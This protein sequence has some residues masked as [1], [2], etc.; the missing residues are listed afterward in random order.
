MTRKPEFCLNVNGQC[1]AKSSNALSMRVRSKATN[2]SRCHGSLATGRA[3]WFQ[4]SRVSIVGGGARGPQSRGGY[5]THW[6]RAHRHSTPTAASSAV[7]DGALDD[8]VLGNNVWILTGNAE[9]LSL[10]MKNWVEDFFRKFVTF[11]SISCLGNSY[12]V[13]FFYW[14]VNIIFCGLI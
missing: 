7:G 6:H 8:I 3:I 13:N 12:T 1:T 14:K 2:R 9:F 4:V 5:R 11:V 10:G